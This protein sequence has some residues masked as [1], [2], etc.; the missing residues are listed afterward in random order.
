VLAL[1]APTVPA[2]HTRTSAIEMSCIGF[3]R[4]QP[5][6]ADLWVSG[7]EE[8][9]RTTFLSGGSLVYVDGSKVS[10]LKPGE[11]FHVVRPEGKIR[12]RHTQ[13][14]VGT[15]YKE[16]GT[17]RIETVRR[18]GATGS[19]LRSCDVI[20]KGDILLPVPG[21]AGSNYTG[22]LS[23][24]TTPFPEDG[25]ASSILVGKDDAREMAA[26]QFCFIGVGNRDGVKLGD[27]FT[28]YR[29]QPG[30]DPK[31]LVVNKSH[32]MTS[33]EPAQSA[34]YHGDI[35]EILSE[36]KLP[37][38]VLGDIVVVDLGETTAAAKIVSSR[39]EIHP[40]DLVVRR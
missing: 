18:D 23:N 35:I 16:L 40:G 29:P 37:P 26:G 22:P 28:I 39:M 20:L 5:V 25:L 19:V 4:E 13:A 11:T 34:R 1:A 32:S 8:E 31:D 2:Q 24:R 7:T 3:I 36:R 21:K 30:F 27:H 6:S 17:I 12:E 33:Y 9:G 10:G 14:N 38:R 15:Y